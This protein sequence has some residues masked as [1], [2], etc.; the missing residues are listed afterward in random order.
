MDGIEEDDSKKSEEEIDP[1]EK[2]VSGIVLLSCGV[3][4][5]VDMAPWLT[6]WWNF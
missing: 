5:D 2:T 4:L 6:A 1:R 3:L